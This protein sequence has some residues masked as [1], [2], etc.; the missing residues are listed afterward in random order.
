MVFFLFPNTLSPFYTLYTII[1]SFWNSSPMQ[2]IMKNPLI[3]SCVT[4]GM[5]DHEHDEVPKLCVKFAYMLNLVE[6]SKVIGNQ[7]VGHRPMHSYLIINW[8]NFVFVGMKAAT[9][10]VESGREEVISINLL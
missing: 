1:P 6:I 7:K 8:G 3:D 4:K 2:I 9:L 10:R 5:N